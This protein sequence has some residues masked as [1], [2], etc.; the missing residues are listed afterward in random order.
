MPSVPEV[1]YVVGDTLSIELEGLGQEM[2]IAARS[3]ATYAVRY[4]SG[5]SGGPR[6][7]A[8][9]ESLS[10]DVATPLTEPMSLDE[11]AVEG[12]FVFEPDSRGRALSTSSPRTSGGAQVFSAPIVAHTLFPRVAGRVVS[13]GDSWIDSVTYSEENE[14]GETAVRSRLTY[15]VVRE[16]MDRGRAIL[17]VDFEGTAEVSQ[18]LSIEGAAITQASEVEVVGSLS[19]D[20]SAG[21]MHES[22]VVME[23]TGSVR[24]ALLPVAL[25]TRVRWLTRVQM[26]D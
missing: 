21:L 1:T 24:A 5:S 2:E 15:T 10:A 25:P 4:A 12:E 7:T 26:Q 8:T 9:L 22:E 3:R 19:W 20:T 18:A 23:G 17:E 6:V 16:S 14:A 13:V 11:G